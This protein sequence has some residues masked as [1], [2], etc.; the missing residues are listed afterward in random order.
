MMPHIPRIGILIGPGDPFWVQIREVLS[1]RA[2][3][4]PAELIEIDLHADIQLPHEE[5]VEFVEDLL[6]QGLDALICN[7][8]PVELLCSILDAGIPII[9][10]SEI[11]FS[12]ERLTT[13]RG[14]Y[15]AAFMIGTFLHQQLQGRGQIL[16][17]GGTIAPSGESRLAG[18]ADTLPGNAHY[19]LHYVPSLWSY[20]DARARVASYLQDHPELQ[21]DAI[22]GLSDSLALAARDSS[23]AA[24]R[25]NREALVLGING[26]PLAIAAIASGNMAAT[27]ETDV[28]DIVAQ[29]LDL[30]YRAARGEQLPPHF[31][32]IQRLITADNLV[33]VAVRKMISLANLPT[34][35]VGVNRRTEQQRVIQLETSLAINR[36]VGLI[37]DRHKLSLAITELIRENYGYDHARLL[38]W[39][40]VSGQLHEVGQDEATQPQSPIHLDPDGPLA[41]ALSHNRAVFTPDT[42][43]GQ[44]VA[45]DP[46]WPATRARAVVPV[47]LGGQIIGLLDLHR[48]R[49]VHQ[50]RQEV[51]G[52]QLLADQLGIAMRNAELYDQALKARAAAEQADRLKT[53]LLANVSHDLREPLN[54]I[55]GQSRFL[56]D[57]VPGTSEL[58]QGLQQI[59][60]SGEH[61][62]RLI[63]DL[64]DLSCAEIGELQILPEQIELQSFLAEIFRTSANHF[65]AMG[66]VTWK[67]DIPPALPSIQADPVR[68]RQVLLNLLHNAHKFTQHGQITLGAEATASQ[69]HLWVA[70]TGAGISHE[71]QE[72]IFEPFVSVESGSPRH[73]G[74]GLGLSIVRRLVELHYGQIHLASSQGSGST[75]HI[76]LPLSQREAP[77]AGPDARTLLL[78]KPVPGQTLIT[79][80]KELHPD[81]TNGSILI[82]DDDPQ[83]RLLHHQIVAEQMPGY[84]IHSAESGQAAL[85]I[86]ERETPSLLVLD[87]V[88]PEVDGFAVLK[89]IRASPR[90][91]EIPVLVISGR[92]L[93]AEDA[94]RLGE[95]RAFFQTKDVLTEYELGETLH[96]TLTHDPA[97]APHTR[98]LVKRAL[99]FIQQHHHI[100]IT[101]QDI[102]KSVGVSKDYLGRIFHQELGLSP[103]DYLN[104]YRILQAKRLLQT[105]NY[106]IAEVARRVGFVDAAYFSRIFHREAGCPPRVFAQGHGVRR[107]T[108]R[109]RP[110]SARDS[111]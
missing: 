68:L 89:A 10:I 53:R 86:L 21:L 82:V 91:R 13:R 66:A 27:V 44:R 47:R 72:H 7:G 88:M 51:D 90:T 103:W 104:R 45:P 23:Q 15:D 2:S 9:Y 69:L 65:G 19:T 63:N 98:E 102:A 46:G 8:E 78:L 110:T 17:V 43:T 62:L 111:P 109:F 87:L 61:L 100:Q 71:L 28:D 81:A 4:L 97:L 106:S 57:R 83:T 55:L 14:L 39:D 32:N 34:R 67:L 96:R 94:A 52:L 64:L 107:A 85:A 93:S 38:I 1:Q 99:A 74:I 92:A 60:Y 76:Y 70:D 35:L 48:K 80:I 37:L 31:Y 101:R 54:F 11:E 3:T 16:V 75:F 26:D 77:A 105:T 73:E 58:A 5:Q 29:M 56:E 25:I 20:E 6:A 108:G 40:S 79:A 18:F 24:G 36:Q 49:A 50:M 95:A 84:T 33:E 41:H 12:H 30:A 59:H 42:R 22:Y